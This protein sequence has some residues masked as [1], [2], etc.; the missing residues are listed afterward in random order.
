MGSFLAACDVTA[1]HEIAMAATPFEHSPL[2]PTDPRAIR[3]LKLLPSRNLKG[4]VRCELHHCSL[5]D[6][7]QYEAMSYTWGD[8]EPG[9]TV[10]V[11]GSYPLEVTPNCVETLVHMRRRFYQRTLWIDSICIDQRET[12][13]SKR[14]RDR[15]VRIMGDVYRAA[16]KVLVWLGPAE[17]ST[18]RTFARLKLISMVEALR[19]RLGCS[20]FLTL[21]NYL[22]NRMSK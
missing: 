3:L 17:P 15:Q 2:D 10:L 1:G 4:P 21:E 18:A 7:Y 19:R 14:E 9:H 12:D 5:D 6:K 16:Q 13:T 20:A 8:P 22:S 11:N